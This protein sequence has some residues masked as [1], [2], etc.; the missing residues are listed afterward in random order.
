MTRSFWGAKDQND[1]IYLHRIV[2]NPDSPVK[3]IFSKVL[4]WALDYAMKHQLKYIRMDTWAENTQLINYYKSYGFSFVEN[5]KTGDNNELPI[6][7]R[8]LNVAL[9]QLEVISK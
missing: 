2:A 7:N 6:Q 4:D 8:N 3:K 1:A 9:L 5:F